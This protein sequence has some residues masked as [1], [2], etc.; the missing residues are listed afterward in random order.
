MPI[1]NRNSLVG[2]SSS[3][4][5]NSNQNS[6]YSNFKKDN[7]S[8]MTSDHLAKVNLLHEYFNCKNRQTFCKQNL[9]NKNN[10]KRAVLIRDQLEE[11]LKQIIE[12][13]KKKSF[14][15]NIGSGQ[16]DNSQKLGV[17]DTK[18]TSESISNWM[19]CMEKCSVYNIAKLS[20]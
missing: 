17:N 7:S 12:E 15:T 5:L 4:G 6:A 16:K 2:S 10:I 14:F 20:N 8:L 18:L 19:K 13:R 3:S 1:I 9:L 11:Y